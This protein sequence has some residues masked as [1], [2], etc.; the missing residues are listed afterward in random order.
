VGNINEDFKLEAQV[1]QAARILSET[2][3][4][5]I[6]VELSIS[7]T[8]LV[9]VDYQ[10]LTDPFFVLFMSSSPSSPMR[11]I[12][13]SEII[14]NNLNPEW[15]TLIKVNYCFEELQL[16]RIEV[17]DVTG[18]FSSSCTDHLCLRDQTLMGTASF[19]LA[20]VLGSDNR[21]YS[22]PLINAPDLTRQEAAMHIKAEE[23]VS[24]D[25]KCHL[26]F[27][28]EGVL[29]ETK[30]KFF[31]RLS[32]RQEDGGLLHFYKTEAVQSSAPVW[33]RISTTLQ[34]LANGDMHRP[35]VFELFNWHHSGNH[36]SIGTCEASVNDLVRLAATGS[37]LSLSGSKQN[38]GSLVFTQ[39]DCVPIPSF[40]DYVFGEGMQINVVF[41][42]DF[43]KSNG[44]PS[45]PDSLH[46]F[47]HA[48]AMD[49]QYAQAIQAVGS[50][51]QHYDTD[52]KYPV[53]GFGAK[54]SPGKPTSHLFA[55]NG[56]EKDAEVNG[57]EGVL[58]CYR[59]ALQRVELHGP[60][61]FTPVINKAISIAQ[62]ARS[63]DPCQQQYFIL[64]ILT[65]GIINDMQN[66]TD[67]IV[68]ASSLPLS[69]IIVG[70][71]NADFAA[72]ETLDGDT[73]P[74]TSAQGIQRERDIVQFVP[75][76]EFIHTSSFDLAKSVLAEIPYQIV[77]YMQ[78]NNIPP[79]PPRTKQI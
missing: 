12:K 46:Y 23:V 25:A 42:I 79:P 58:S 22:T 29:A 67:A 47:S 76:K 10:S 43:T 3:T 27:R 21:F 6:P 72:M 64:L 56:N 32:R 14:A 51:L 55:V 15:V 34:Q 30:P 26:Q 75:Y 53:Y 1:E 49:N 44:D 68:A 31:V 4:S 2:P 73:I 39:C 19:A 52:K 61:I 74:L 8:N 45:H 63:K 20:Q 41:A 37:R 38:N 65:D 69:I 59:A 24:Q 48:E 11:E 18:S 77:S 60:T 70:V 33:K 28:A 50:V 66:T 54:V 13:R 16:I 78:A 35:V 40:F 62:A 5:F 71:G 7:C 36:A 17:Y 9:N 57:I